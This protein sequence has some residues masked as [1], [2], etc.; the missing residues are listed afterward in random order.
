MSAKKLPTIVKQSG[1][2]YMPI[3]LRIYRYIY[4]QSLRDFKV[5]IV[6]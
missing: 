2:Q 1:V 4:P 5:L 6:I 3:D